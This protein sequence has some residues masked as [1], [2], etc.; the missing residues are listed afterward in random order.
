MMFAQFQTATN[1]KK[2]ST[3]Y[4]ISGGQCLF[5][6]NANFI[7]GTFSGGSGLLEKNHQRGSQS[8]S[9]PPLDVDE[10]D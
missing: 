6:E 1:A 3:V 4:N 7:G 2:K 8:E 5:N 10:L 9:Q